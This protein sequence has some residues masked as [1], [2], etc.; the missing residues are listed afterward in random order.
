MAE[1]A[2]E[3][4]KPAGTPILNGHGKVPAPSEGLGQ[5]ETQLMG[6]FTLAA[7]V[8]HGSRTLDWN[9]LYA[10]EVGRSALLLRAR[11]LL[12]QG[13]Q[14]LQKAYDYVKD[15]NTVSADFEITLFQGAVPELFC[16]NQI[17]EGFAAIVV[18]LNWALKNRRGDPL[19]P[20]QLRA[21][22]NCVGRLNNELFLKYEVALDLIDDFENVGLNTDPSIAEPLATLL[23]DETN[24]PATNYD[25]R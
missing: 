25:N 21:I 11:V 15:E 16:C 14:S 3:L 23:I 13:L 5:Y 2:Y 24:E 22:L 12:A 17:S 6:S 7:T 1:A 8:M 20:E 18:A 4:I 9:E 19:T 10:G